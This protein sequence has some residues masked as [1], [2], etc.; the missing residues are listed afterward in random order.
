MTV[1]E[2]LEA[3]QA[4]VE[5]EKK[6]FSTVLDKSLRSNKTRNKSYQLISCLDAKKSAMITSCQVVPIF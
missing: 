3:L 5:K 1:N 6:K 4:Q 2:Q